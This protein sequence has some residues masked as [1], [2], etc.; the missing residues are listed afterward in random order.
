MFEVF[1]EIHRRHPTTAELPLDGVAVGQCCRKTASD[2]I[3]HAGDLRWSRDL[4]YT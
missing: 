2:I 1:G 4:N 3:G